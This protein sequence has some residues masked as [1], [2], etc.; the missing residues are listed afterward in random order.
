MQW[1]AFAQQNVISKRES[2][3]GTV[4]NAPAHDL[5]RC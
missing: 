5:L 1:G 4:I 3:Q 2:D